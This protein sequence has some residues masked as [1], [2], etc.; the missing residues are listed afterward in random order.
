MIV[1]HKN[2]YH[3]FNKKADPWESALSFIM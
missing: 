3:K 2:T 1:E